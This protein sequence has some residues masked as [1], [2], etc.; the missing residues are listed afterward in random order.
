MS[1]P[2]SGTIGTAGRNAFRGP[3][4]FNLD[5]SLLKRF[6]VTET[7]AFTFRAE[8]YNTLNS[9]RFETPGANLGTPASLG[10]FSGTIGGARTM[11]M[12]LRFDF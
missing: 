5:A 10:K 11:Q 3:R 7:K 6:R 9:A 2:E 12:A 1:F 4:Y 8:A